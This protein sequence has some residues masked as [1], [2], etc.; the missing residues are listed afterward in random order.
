MF[1]LMDEFETLY[2]KQCATCHDLFEV[3]T[4]G[5]PC[6]AFHCYDCEMDYIQ[7]F[8]KGESE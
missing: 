4:F 3:E 7:R 6:F 5:H 2:L 1:L 8:D